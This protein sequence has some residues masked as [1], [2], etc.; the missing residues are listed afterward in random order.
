MSEKIKE[1]DSIKEKSN[2]KPKIL[3]FESFT[4]GSFKIIDAEGDKV[5]E[6]SYRAPGKS[7][8]V[9]AFL[10]GSKEERIVSSFIKEAKDHQSGEE[11]VKEFFKKQGY[12]IEG[13]LSGK[14]ENLLVE[15]KLEEGKYEAFKAVL[16]EEEILIEKIDKMI[17]MAPNRGEAERLALEKY[18]E[19][20][21]KV[22][23]RAKQALDDW[24]EGINK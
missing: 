1:V 21:D 13:I 23:K 24:L 19:E 4:D 5:A 17:T 20:L 11:L 18:G 8:Y 2:E 9:Y 3:K 16:S 15:K 10:P 22:I 14:E 12:V 6:G 7:F